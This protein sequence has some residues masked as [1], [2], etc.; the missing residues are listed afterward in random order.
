MWVILTKVVE[1]YNTESYPLVVEATILSP[2]H[3]FSHIHDESASGHSI[4]SILPNHGSNRCD[5]L[6][7]ML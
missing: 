7:C 4:I 1:Q 6:P 5:P 2:T 3:Y